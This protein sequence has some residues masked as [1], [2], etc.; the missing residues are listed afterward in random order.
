LFHIP[1]RWEGIVGGVKEKLE[2]SLSL[3]SSNVVSGNW[4]LELLRGS[5]IRI[6]NVQDNDS[7]QDS[8]S[9]SNIF[10]GFKFLETTWTDNDFNIQQSQIDAK[11][12][13]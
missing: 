12:N 8:M 3:S 9:I 10:G 1:C 2:D 6:S 13:E 4:D 7:Q 11:L 5:Q